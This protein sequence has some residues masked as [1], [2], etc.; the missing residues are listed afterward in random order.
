M[1][2]TVWINQSPRTAPFTSS[3]SGNPN[4]APIPVFSVDHGINAF[5]GRTPNVAPAHVNQPKTFGQFVSLIKT[6]TINHG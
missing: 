2:N 6:V 3:P 1:N 4:Y 5:G